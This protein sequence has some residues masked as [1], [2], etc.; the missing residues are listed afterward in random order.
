MVG[1]ANV[2]RGGVVVL[3]LREFCC[4]IKG[5]FI[6]FEGLIWVADGAIRPE[7]LEVSTEFNRRGNPSVDRRSGVAVLM[8]VGVA[9]RE[10]EVVREVV[11]WL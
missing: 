4:T 1:E 5:T 11:L 2:R 3:A 6:A 10:R 9:D 7:R 8:G